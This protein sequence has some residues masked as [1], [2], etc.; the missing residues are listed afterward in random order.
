MSR[1]VEEMHT[2]RRVNEGLLRAIER[3]ELKKKMFAAAYR[4]RRLRAL[5]D[6]ACQRQQAA[7]E[8]NAAVDAAT[9]A[10]EMAVHELYQK[11][12]AKAAAAAAAAAAARRRACCICC[13]SFEDDNG[14]S[15]A[16]EHFTCNDCLVGCI[17]VKFLQNL[18]VEDCCA[19][20]HLMRARYHLMRLPCT[21]CLRTD[22]DGA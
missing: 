8:L 13:D 3:S 12:A 21:L 17:K 9:C 5:A 22:V 19:R 16:A 10:A 4:K 6:K 18:P 20:Y 1:H 15:C 11:E 2:L 7:I 14:V